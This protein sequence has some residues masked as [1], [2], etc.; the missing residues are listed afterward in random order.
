MKEPQ[1]NQ[2]IQ[3]SR[4]QSG[5]SV[6]K[7]YVITSVD[8]TDNTL[9][10]VDSDGNAGFWLSWDD[11][12][13]LSNPVCWEW[14]NGRLSGEALELLSAFEGVEKLSLKP[15]VRDRML[16]Q[17]PNL[18]DRILQSQIQLEEERGCAGAEF[19]RCANRGPEAAAV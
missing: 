14:L 7:V 1:I 17:L 13:I 19:P 3:V 9:I 15:L 18:K 11:C 8:S 5:Y 4:N 6:G 12:V 16:T 10:A 2:R